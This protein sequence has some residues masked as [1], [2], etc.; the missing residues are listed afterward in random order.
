MQ[1]NESVKSQM[2]Q[3]AVIEKLALLSLE[4]QQRVLA[5]AEEIASQQPA[6]SKFRALFEDAAKD[7]PPEAFDEIPPDASSNIDR[8]IY[9]APEK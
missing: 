9:G 4:K 8:R 2:I 7:I 3:Q 6:Q 5:F 1:T